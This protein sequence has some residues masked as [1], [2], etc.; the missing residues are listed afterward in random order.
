MRQ[1]VARAI[2]LGLVLLLALGAVHQPRPARAEPRLQLLGQ[3]S[4]PSGRTFQDTTVGG[5]SGL[6][7]DAA[8]QVYYAVSDD[9]GERQPARFYTLEIDLG[10]AG[11]GD[12]RVVGVTTLD[13]DAA[14]P[15]VQPYARNEIDAEEIAL[16]GPDEILVSSE[17]DLQARPWL[18]RFGLDGTLRGELPLPERYQPVSEPG[19][20]G[21]PSPI[22]G[23]RGNLG[24]E[25]LGLTAD[26]RALYLANE[27]ALVQDGPVATVEAGSLVRLLRY[28]RGAEWQPGVE[29]A[30]AVERI[31]R[32]PNP[33]E[34]FADNGLS[35]LLPIDHLWPDLDLLTMERSYATGLGNDVSLY[36]VR[37]LGARPTEGLAALPRPFEGPLAGKV[38]LA[39]LSDL[40]VMPDNLEA[41][42]LG[43]RLP[44]GR[45]SLIVMSDDNF[46]DAGSVQL[47]Q[48]LLFELQGTILETRPPAPG[49]TPPPAPV[50]VPA[51]LPRTGTR[52]VGLPLAGLA[53]AGLGLALRRLGRRRPPAP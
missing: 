7:Y 3:F 46:S 31:P 29:A 38:R 5:L 1:R 6:T 13:S 30:Y 53:L 40:G 47:N 26:G 12:V 9:R 8:R 25:G 24:F 21:R 51:A 14:M 17:R 45:P 50:Q 32:P 27:A 20:D 48:F 39:R 35:A 18:R 43:P 4:F 28:E 42:A 36:G 33:P 49:P 19:P 22:H 41:L 11:I 15:G 16:L 34:A 2:V 23:V 10:P 37:L 44:N 52:E